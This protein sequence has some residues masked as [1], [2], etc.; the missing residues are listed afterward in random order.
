ME[1]KNVDFLDE[2]DKVILPPV[3]PRSPR[4]RFFI[5]LAAAIVVCV[6]VFGMSVISSGEN[7]SQTFGNVSLWDQLK[8]L[9]SSDEKALRGENQDR[10]NVLLLGIGGS[11]HDGPYLSDTIMVG[12][13]KP[14]TNQVALISIPRDLLVSIPGYGWRKINNASAFGELQN[15]GKGGELARDVVSQ[16]LNIPIHYYVRIDFSGFVQLVDDLGGITVKVENTLDDPFYPVKGKETA[17]TTERYEH[18]YIEPGS[19]HFNGSQA[20]KYVRSRQAKGIEG[21][22]FARSKRQQN[23]LLAIKEKTLSFSVLANPI[24]LSRLMDTLSQHL[25]TDFQVWEILGLFN[26]GK[27]LSPD[28]VT[29]R[30]FDDSP[31]G[32]LYPSITADGAFVLMPKAGG[33]EELQSIAKNIFD[34]EKIETE[35][36]KMV[37][38][39]NGTKI[40]GLAYRISQYLQSLGYQVVR[41]KNAPTQDYEK[42]VVYDLTGADQT[43]ATISELI[44]AALAPTLPGWVTATS[45]SA[46]SPNADILIILGKDQQ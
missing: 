37:E 42:T 27:S 10:I 45:S 17:T 39:Q 46:V 6:V 43:A 34:P 2:K 24:K 11:D 16:V 23:I 12:S 8:L 21:S 28:D 31:D 30:V 25:A 9:I 41:I 20:L 15:P 19:H 44:N 35:K 32:P 36:P 40:N 26:M 33:F 1:P 13:F 14:S 38:I 29:N 3:R 7:L 4:R 5:Y 18:L 22:D